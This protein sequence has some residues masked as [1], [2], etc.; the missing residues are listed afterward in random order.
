[1]AQKLESSLHL[2]QALKQD[3][4]VFV[5]KEKAGSALAL[6]VKQ[7]LLTHLHTK[8][9]TEGGYMEED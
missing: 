4:E 6:Q 8:I 2:L 9:L 7:H 1:M 3:V 5:A